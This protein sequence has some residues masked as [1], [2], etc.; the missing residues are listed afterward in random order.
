VVVAV[1]IPLAVGFVRFAS[2]LPQPTDDQTRTDAIVVLTGGR[3]RIAAGLALLK[4]G[5]AEK[6][7][8]SGVHPGVELADLLKR[9]RTGPSAPSPD[10]DLAGRIDLGHAA[11][12]T[13]GNSVETVEWMRANQFHSMRLVTADYHMPRALIEFRMADPNIDIVANP[14]RPSSMADKK[15][16]QNG[17]TFK[18]L[19]G[20]YGK[21]LI[22]KWRYIFAR[23]LG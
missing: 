2:H 5:K 17:A 7:F 1:A 12:D 6:L 4:N 11:G 22:A 19:F 20:E 23:W 9:D 18:L 8:V 15:W 14:V 21:Y 13:F 3:E 16:W 10:A